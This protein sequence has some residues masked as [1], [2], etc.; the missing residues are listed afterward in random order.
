VLKENLNGTNGVPISLSELQM[1][2]SF[3]LFAGFACALLTSNG[4]AQPASTIVGWFPAGSKP[5][6]YEMSIDA[7]IK[8]SGKFSARV[9]NKGGAV[10]DF[11][12]L[13]QAIEAEVYRGKRLRLSGWLKTADATSAQMWMRVHTSPT[14][15]VGFDNM[16]NRP[17]KGTSEWQRYAIVL[18]IP[19]DATYIAFGALLFGTGKLWI[20]NFEL[21]LVGGE[22]PSTNSLTPEEVTEDK[23]MKG[24]RNLGKKALNLNF[25]D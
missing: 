16:D 9:S 13:M 25:E 3:R 4:I 23:E 7:S 20:D 18:D 5:Q 12:T 2:L 8:H 6:N 24:I 11:G 22:I 17:I 19:I 15:I 1:T 21:S 14:R 10:D